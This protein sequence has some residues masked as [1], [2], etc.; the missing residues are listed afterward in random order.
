MAPQV[1]EKRLLLVRLPPAQRAMAKV[2]V[3]AGFLLF[4]NP[5]LMLF[6]RHPSLLHAEGRRLLVKMGRRG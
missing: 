2:S 3:R 5:T 6:V 4:H 1:Q